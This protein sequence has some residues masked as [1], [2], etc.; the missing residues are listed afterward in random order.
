MPVTPLKASSEVGRIV[1]MDT[2]ITIATTLDL[3]EKCGEHQ[4]RN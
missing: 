2:A 3:P 1:A 4:L